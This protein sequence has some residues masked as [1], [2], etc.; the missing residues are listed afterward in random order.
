M[1]TPEPEKGRTI[2][3]VD[4]HRVCRD[5]IVRSLRVL[6]YRALEAANQAEAQ[7][8]LVLHRGRLAALVVDLSLESCG[9]VAI[10]RRLGFDYPRAPV[11]FIS[12]HP[13]EM[14]EGLAAGSSCRFLQK[15]FSIGQL[16][17]ALGDLLTAAE[18]GGA[19]GHATAA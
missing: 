10:T 14:Y 8:Q 4:D 17:R 6:G 9:D 18:R 12:G 16:E 3:V 19:G 2:L 15:P 7:Q 11:L 5:L 13:A 1:P